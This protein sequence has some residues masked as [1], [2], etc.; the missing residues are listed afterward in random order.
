MFYCHAGCT[1]SDILTAAGLE[2]KD[3][4]YDSKPLKT[5]WQAYVESREKRK[6]EAVY[7]YVSFNGN[8][9]FTKIRLEGK[10][11]LYGILKDDR[12]SYGL[13]RNTPRKSLKAIYGS[14]KALNKAVTEGEIIFIPEGEKDVDTLVKHGYTAFTYGGCGDWQVAF[15]DLVKNANVIILADND[16]PGTTVA[17]AILKDIQPVLRVQRLL[18][19]FLMSQRQI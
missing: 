6:I 13:P 15:A 14:V 16:R 2:K 11:L 19:L 17:N 7:N 3:T 12:F 18:Y 9:A 10:K 8:Y 1:L 4:F 5:N